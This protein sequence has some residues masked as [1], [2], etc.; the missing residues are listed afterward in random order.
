[1]AVFVLQ[2]TQ[3]KKYE[4]TNVQKNKMLLILN[5]IKTLQNWHQI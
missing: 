3:S 4:S 2:L 5:T 1:M